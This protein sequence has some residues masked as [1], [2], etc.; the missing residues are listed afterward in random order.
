MKL[1]DPHWLDSY[2]GFVLCKGCVVFLLMA[3]SFP[4]E[5]LYPLS[6]SD[7]VAQS[8]LRKLL[9]RRKQINRKYWRA[10][11]SGCCL[12]CFW[13]SA[14]IHSTY[15]WHVRTRH[16]FSS[17]HIVIKHIFSV[18]ISLALQVTWNQIGPR[19][20]LFTPGRDLSLCCHRRRGNCLDAEWFMYS[21]VANE[22]AICTGELNHR[23]IVLPFDL[24]FLFLFFSLSLVIGLSGFFNVWNI[25]SIHLAD[26][27]YE[28]IRMVVSDLWVLWSASAWVTQETR[29]CWEAEDLGRGGAESSVMM[30][31]LEP[32]A[33]PP[34]F[35]NNLCYW[36]SFYVDFLILMKKLWYEIKMKILC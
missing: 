27:R 34:K 4:P 36:N 7:P 26:P 21:F 17:P 3:T 12:C 35:K 22:E 15:L 32:G 1:R 29:Y 16:L 33:F 19:F 6:I 9:E 18:F 10:L 20:K 8:S 24:L 11:I 2:L 5:S 23:Y 31:T 28:P 25:L 30:P 13:S 14:D